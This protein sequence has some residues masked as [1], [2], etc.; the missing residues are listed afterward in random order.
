[1]GEPGRRRA[2][3]L[4]QQDPGLPGDLMTQG[5]TGG[6]RAIAAASVLALILAAPIGAA[7]TRDRSR[8]CQAGKK[9]AATKTTLLGS[10]KRFAVVA[11]EQPPRSNLSLA[12]SI[13]KSTASALS[14]FG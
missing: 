2:A 6:V 7:K 1:V 8:S 12:G 3:R 13:A 14:V 11:C 4:D 5:Y 10:K 9:A